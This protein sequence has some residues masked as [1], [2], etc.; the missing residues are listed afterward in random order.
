MF[1]L[2]LEECGPSS[3]YKS[4]HTL[5]YKNKIISNLPIQALRT[6]ATYPCWIWLQVMKFMTYLIVLILCSLC[7][8][9]DSTLILNQKMSVLVPC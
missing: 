2:K 9:I 6:T 4:L 8:N 5:H 3:L 1:L 7:S